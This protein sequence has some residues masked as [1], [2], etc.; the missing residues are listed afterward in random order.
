MLTFTQ[1]TLMEL[2]CCKRDLTR[3]GDH[4]DSPPLETEKPCFNDVFKQLLKKRNI[5]QVC[6]IFLWGF[7][8]QNY[9]EFP[10]SRVPQ[11]RRAP[12]IFWSDYELSPPTNDILAL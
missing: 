8:I 7:Y 9:C 4:R 2:E 1:Q 11:G 5:R 3:S 12:V 6:S 10:K